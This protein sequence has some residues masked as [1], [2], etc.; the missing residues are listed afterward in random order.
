MTPKF[1]V[2]DMVKVHGVHN[3]EVIAILPPVGFAMFV[4]YKV[5]YDGKTEDVQEYNIQPNADAEKPKK[6]KASDFQ[7]GLYIPYEVKIKESGKVSVLKVDGIE[8]NAEFEKLDKATKTNV[9]FAT[10]GKYYFKKGE[11]GLSDITGR[12]GSFNEFEVEDGRLVLWNDTQKTMKKD[13]VKITW[14]E[15]TLE[16]LSTS[17]DDYML[18][19]YK[20]E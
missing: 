16:A 20:I 2:G 13:D 9:K 3:G 7:E 6:S 14:S 8:K 19:T 15:D 5:A 11:W 18:V 12:Y 10:G 4:R 17:G 1:K